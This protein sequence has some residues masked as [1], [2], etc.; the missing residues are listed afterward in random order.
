MP[1]LLI[2]DD[3]PLFRD[4][5]RTAVL[6]VW[7]DAVIHEAE[8]VD[9]V[10]QLIEQCAE[11]D[12]LLLDLSMPGSTGFDPLVHIRAR[13][14]QL[15]VVIVSGHD[16]LHTMRR[17]MD[18]GAMGYIPKSSDLATI[19]QAL[20][21]VLDGDPWFLPQALESSVA[22]ANQQEQDV[23][24]RM[25]E[26][27]PQQAKVLQM[28]VAGRLNKQIAHDLGTSEATV[29]AHMSAILR[30]LGATNRTE[31]VSMAHRLGVR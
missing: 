16:D 18:H 24:A 11:A 12:L 9:G 26:L 31:A 21:A 25:A 1:T 14:P 3:H 4:A 28:A 30:K 22:S 6:R 2:A 17:A 10:Y 8:H 20:Q 27:T 7:P 29:K 5:L 15:P 23:A 19:G 13:H